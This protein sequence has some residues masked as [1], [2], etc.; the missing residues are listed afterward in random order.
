M[1]IFSFSWNPVLKL[2]QRLGLLYYISAVQYIGKTAQY[3]RKGK[4]WFLDGW[5]LKT[6]TACE[7]IIPLHSQKPPYLYLWRKVVCFVLFCVVLYIWD[8]L[9]RNVSGPVLGM[10]GKL[11]TRARRA[12]AW[13][14]AVW[15]CG[16]KV[17]EYWMV[18]SL[19][20]IYL[21]L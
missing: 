1:L 16:A 17:P 9:N 10:F 6:V 12:W 18:F 8:P 2:G 11:W 5:G 19:E 3:I 15:T 14:H 20:K 13:F 4:G 21:N 7:L